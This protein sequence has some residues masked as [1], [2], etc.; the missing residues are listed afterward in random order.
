[1]KKFWLDYG[2]YL[3]WLIVLLATG[4]SLFF[5]EVLKLPPCVLC[6][7]QRVFMYP[8]VIILAVG[9]LR[10][11]KKI[12]QYVLPMSIIGLLIAI[13]H[14]LLYYNV[15]PESLSPCTA[16]ISCTTKLI[17]WFGFITIPLLSLTAFTLITVIMLLYRY[18]QKSI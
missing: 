18:Y 17:E 7:Y 15:I 14:N 3:S 13:Y 4:G 6:W 12:Y 5:S 2:V 1:M 10:K 8:L 9:I 16:G 11:E